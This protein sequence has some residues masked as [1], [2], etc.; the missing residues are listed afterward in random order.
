MFHYVTDAPISMFWLHQLGITTK[1]FFF[2]FCYEMMLWHSCSLFCHISMLF[3]V[4]YRP[5]SLRSVRDAVMT[6][7]I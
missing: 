1:L 5:T 3:S 4:T 2:F 6:R 7:E